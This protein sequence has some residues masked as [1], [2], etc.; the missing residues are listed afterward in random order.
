MWFLRYGGLNLSFCEASELKFPHGPH[1]ARDG[2][3]T[4]FPVV[5]DNECL[6]SARH[7]SPWV[8]V[9]CISHITLR[10]LLTHLDCVYNRSM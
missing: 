1:R 9:N 3:T 6:L 7:L 5:V 10:R 8:Q 4:D 2:K